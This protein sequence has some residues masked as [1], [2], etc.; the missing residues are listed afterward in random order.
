VEFS[1]LRFVDVVVAAPV[2]RL[3]H[4]SAESLKNE[5]GPVLD[6]LAS[7]HISLVLDFSG[8]DYISSM[9]LRALMIA[10]KQAR[11]QNTRIGVA[12]LQPIVNEIFQISRFNHVLEIYPSVRAAL[13]VLSP[14]ALAAYDAEDKPATS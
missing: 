12:A 13:Q 14:S 7:D 4:S 2:G 5:L 6:D 8:V 1:S 11:S 10:A 9:G 3:D